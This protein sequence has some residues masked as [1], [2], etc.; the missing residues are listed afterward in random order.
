MFCFDMT[1]PGNADSDS[2]FIKSEQVW[3]RKLPSSIFPAC[4]PEFDVI[5]G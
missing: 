4:S 1:S 3:S 5:L 2:N